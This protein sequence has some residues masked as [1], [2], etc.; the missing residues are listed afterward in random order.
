MTLPRSP[1]NPP[2]PPQQAERKVNEEADRSEKERK[3]AEEWAAK[4]E[5]E[6]NEAMERE[7]ERLRLEERRARRLAEEKVQRERV[8]QDRLRKLKEEEEAK[9]IE[10]QHRAEEEAL[11]AAEAGEATGRFAGM[12]SVAIPEKIEIRHEAGEVRQTQTTAS[13]PRKTA[14]VPIPVA[15]TTDLASNVTEGHGT[16]LPSPEMLWNNSGS[17]NPQTNN[18]APPS[19]SALSTARHIEDINRITYPEGIKRPKFE[20]N[21]NAQMGKFRYVLSSSDSSFNQNILFFMLAMIA[22]SCYSS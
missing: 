11:R 21:V 14:S 20:L 22:T 10:Q 15:V 18:S 17:R 4:E 9:A 2:K 8:Q 5:A 13:L 1:R 16:A 6:L 12:T 19:P 3:E 7:K